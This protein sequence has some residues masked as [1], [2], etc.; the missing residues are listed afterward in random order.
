MELHRG[1]AG[2]RYT[3]QDNEAEAAFLGNQPPLWSNIVTIVRTLG[4]VSFILKY[5]LSKFRITEWVL[6]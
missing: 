4:L 3:N 2:L 1:L 5:E 6:S